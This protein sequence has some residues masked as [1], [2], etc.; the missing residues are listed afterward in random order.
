[1][2]NRYK[3]SLLYSLI[4]HLIIL[5]L[6]SPILLFE[7]EE[8]LIKID[9]KINLKFIQNE[10]KLFVFEDKKIQKKFE[11][12]IINENDEKINNK[13]PL[14]QGKIGEIE[15]KQE[16]TKNNIL[17]NVMFSEK[18]IFSKERI[19]EKV[20]YK[21]K[22]VFVS[23]KSDENIKIL[24][25]IESI[26]GK[27]Y[28]TLSLEE[29]KY[30]EE[31]YPLFVKILSQKLFYPVISKRLKHEG[32]VYAE[33]SVINGELKID[34]TKKSQ[35]KEFNYMVIDTLEETYKK[36]LSIGENIKHGVVIKFIIDFKK[37]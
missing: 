28:Y 25:N 24:S 33:I 4:L 19:K 1:M 10:E 11:E 15:E 16:I 30:L 18:K 32:I 31:K 17:K 36:L 2:N 22:D 5:I 3:Y 12:N 26:Y 7:N 13:K 6:L 27:E 37:N 35:Y 20:A 8:K 21:E 23:V 14:E 29:I 34:V 9:K